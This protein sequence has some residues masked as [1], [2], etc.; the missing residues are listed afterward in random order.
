MLTTFQRYHRPLSLGLLGLFGLAAGVLAATLLGTGLRSP[1]AP[2]RSAA[3]AAAQPPAVAETELGVIMQY[4]LFS[5]A[6]RTGTPVAFTLRPASGVQEAAVRSDLELLGTIVAG[7]RSLAVIRMGGE[8][9]NYRLESEIPGGRIEKIRRSEVE[10]RNQDRS[11]TVLRPVEPGTAGGSAPGPGTTAAPVRGAASASRG[12]RGAAASAAPAART[13]AKGGDAVRSAGGN[14]WVVAR[15]TAT[16]ARENIGEQLRLVL[17][18]PNLVDG[19]TDG[20]A[21][22]RI[23]PGSL[24]AQMGMQ[25]DDVIKRVN[26]MALDSPEKGLQVMQQLR[27]ARQITVDLVRAGKPLSFSYEIE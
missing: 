11:L 24:L 25:R 14:R 10:I 6:A 5:P 21:I 15:G 4:N 7:S 3:P 12:E 27:E 1:A 8:V 13:G 23:Q 18:Q 16:A 2:A 9:K 20:F 19:K 22:R 17:M 26:G